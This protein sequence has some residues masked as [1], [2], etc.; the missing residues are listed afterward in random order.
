MSDDDTGRVCVHSSDGFP[1]HLPVRRVGAADEPT[2]EPRARV[3]V[4]AVPEPATGRWVP[5]TIEDTTRGPTR[6]SVGRSRSARTSTTV[7]TPVPSVA[8]TGTP[9]RS[10]R[11]TADPPGTPLAESSTG[12]GT[13]PNG[14]SPPGAP[15]IPPHDVPPQPD[16]EPVGR[17]EVLLRPP[18]DVD[19]RVD[20]EDVVER[21][22]PRSRLLPGI[23]PGPHRAS[24]PSEPPRL[25][26]RPRPRPAHQPDGDEETVAVLED[27]VVDLAEH[28]LLRTDDLV[29]EQSQAERDRSDDGRTARRTHCPT[30]ETTSNGTAA[31]EATTTRTRYPVPSALASRPLT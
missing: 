27:D 2:D 23:Q 6:E 5:A 9:R 4:V 17:E 21:H 3:G 25:P 1:R 10:D 30:P 11:S 18:V 14:W 8:T 26:G 28:L 19:R 20:P 22:R 12:S 24:P 16:L 29:V 13:P 15:G 7:P 31:S